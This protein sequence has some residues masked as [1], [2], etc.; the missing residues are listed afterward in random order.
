MDF[1]VFFQTMAKRNIMIQEQVLKYILE[2]GGMVPSSFS[3]GGSGK[4]APASDKQEQ[5][6]LAQVMM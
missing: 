5:E 1:T 4:P 6:L 3:P 2:Q